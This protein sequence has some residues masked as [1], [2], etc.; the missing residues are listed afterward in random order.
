MIL[1]GVE[2]NPGVVGNSIGVGTNLG[3]NPGGAEINPSSTGTDPGVAGA[4]LIG[5]I[6]TNPTGAGTN[7][8]GTIAETNPVR[9][10]TNH[11]G[12]GIIHGGVGSGTVAGALL[13]GT[14]SG[15]SDGVCSAA[16]NVPGSVFRTIP[17][18]GTVLGS[19]PGVVIPGVVIPPCLRC[20]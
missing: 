17:T 13:D 11:G 7:P 18:A 2:T 3:P 16:E 10:P 4:N 5:A 9:A 12:I 8:K 1:G 20:S 15:G 19:S 14:V 6:G